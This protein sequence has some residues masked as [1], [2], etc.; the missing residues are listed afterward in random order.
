MAIR[1]LFFFFLFSSVGVFAQGNYDPAKLFAPDFMNTGATPTRAAD[2]SPGKDYWQNRADYVIDA[3]IKEGGAISASQVITY[4][5]NSP[6]TLHYFWL[7]LDQNLFK[8]DSRG[9]LRLEAGTPS[10]Y[11]DPSSNFSG[12]FNLTKVQVANKAT[13]YIV[14]DTRM[15][16]I[17]EVPLA[18]GQSVTIS[19]DY[20]FA[21][22]EKGADR[23]GILKNPNGDIY[24]VAQWYPRFCVYDDIQGWNAEPYLGPGEFYLEYGNFNVNITA[25][26]N[27]LVAGGGELLNA[28]DVLSAD[29]FARYEKAGNSNS[30]LVIRTDDQRKETSKL[31]GN[32][33]WKFKLENARDFAWAASRSFIWDGCKAS[34]PGG[35]SVFAQS[36]YPASAAGA[37]AWSRSSE[38]TKFSVEHYSNKWFPYPYPVAINIAS[39]VSGMEYP[40]IAFC[41][42]NAKGGGLF[43]VTDHEF[44]HIWFP[45]IVGSNERKYGWM[46][47]GFAS[48]L[49]LE[50]NGVFNNAE[51]KQDLSNYFKY[52]GQSFNKNVEGIML[53]P[54]A[55]KEASIGSSLYSKP[56]YI[57]LSLIHI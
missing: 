47:E 52:V 2:G 13:K 21:L 23:A 14:T 27:M 39:N 10:R 3:T 49:G 37:N 30:T 48:F 34:V 35:K 5:N 16:I 29:E 55:M 45:M 24:S 1:I 38:Y 50:S 56:S 22:P 32:K 17:P 19:I 15:Q 8:T 4:K 43:G 26:A 11:G 20:N 57:L 25:P 44:A 51:Y 12:G 7:Y 9:Q 31:T 42:V 33:T 36:F 41:G 54:D 28:K 18:P 46:D 6:Q 40:A 53:T